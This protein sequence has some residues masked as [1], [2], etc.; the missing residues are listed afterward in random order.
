MKKFIFILVLGLIAFVSKAQTANGV[1]SFTGATVTNT[2][3][4]YLAITAPN[5]IKA[6]Y[7]VTVVIQPTNGTGSPTVTAMPQGSLDGTTYFDLQAAADTINDAGVVANKYYVFAD[8]Y[9]RYYKVKL[10]GSGTGVSTVAGKLGLKI[11]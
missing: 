6:N 1:V 8:S 3:T 4:V 10:V 5:P 7:A 11:K 2:Q 9:W